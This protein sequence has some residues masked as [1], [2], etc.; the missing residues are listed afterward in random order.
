MPLLWCATTSLSIIIIHSAALLLS[1]QKLTIRYEMPA[2]NYLDRTV[3]GHSGHRHFRHS[4]S[5][6]LGMNYPED[7]CIQPDHN[8]AVQY[9]KTPAQKLWR[10]LV[11]PTDLRM[12]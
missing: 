4:D 10:M 7:G 2:W 12:T 5:L 8:L 3:G 9:I 1:R 6:G 11:S